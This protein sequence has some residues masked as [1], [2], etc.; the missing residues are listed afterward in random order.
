MAKP[1][2]LGDY[3]PEIDGL[4]AVAVI[5]VVLFHLGCSWVKGG[6]LGVDVFFVI[7]GFL[8][9]SLLVKE[10][11]RQTF[12]Y[13]RFWLR[14]IRRIFP[15]LAVM[16]II[17]SLAGA[18]IFPGNNV[19]SLGTTGIAALLSFANVSLWRSTDGYWGSTAEALPLLHTWSLS[20]EEQFYFA[21][22]FLL[23]LLFRFARGKVFSA[24]LGV[25]VMSFT[26]YL[27]GSSHH[28]AATFYLLPTR[29]WE[30][31]SGCL[32]AIAQS[33]YQFKP[34]GSSVLSLLGLAAIA[35]SYH[36]LSAEN[37]FPGAIGIVVAGSLLVITFATNQNDP[38]FRL[39]VARPVVFIGKMSY[40]IYL[41]HWPILVLAKNYCN[42]AD[43]PMSDWVLLPIITLASLA[44]YF[45]VEKTTRHRE[46]ILKPASL[47]FAISCALSCFLIARSLTFDASIYSPVLWKGQQY[48]VRPVQTE[49]DRNFWKAMGG[50][51]TPMR[52]GAED[53]AY[54]STGILRQYGGIGVDIVVLGDSH[55]V[56]WAGVLDEIAKDLRLNISFFAATASSPFLDSGRKR[57]NKSAWNADDELAFDRA[58]I[59]RIQEW[60]PRLVLLLTKWSERSMDETPELFNVLEKSRCRV[61]TIEQPPELFF[62]DKNTPRELIKLRIFPK[63]G[64]NQYIRSVSHSE[65]ERYL[66]GKE[67]VAALEARHPWFSCVNIADVFLGRNNKVWVLNGTHVLYIDDDHLSQDGALKAKDRIKSAIERELLEP[68]ILP[69]EARRAAEELPRAT[70]VSVALR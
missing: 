24:I 15:A 26:G 5:P 1:E 63:Q 29:A 12:A 68:A 16:L 69:A 56:M 66:H 39:L 54:K 60:R 35:A 33:R 45:L 37:S 61:L 32:L 9:T 50:I 38:V 57:Q 10:H 59:A 11:D 6:Y 27:Y 25:T 65:E 14:R 70:S 22:P 13:S 31:A 20:V 53:N 28:P 67:V 4:R 44:S 42:Y 55:G 30:L 17:T 46:R 47:A 18:F 8:I 58:R 41:W 3:R 51:Q 2:H 36:F 48:D 43:T 34:K 23:A 40:S 7:S 21:Y 64:V 52:D 49:E 62:G 19:D